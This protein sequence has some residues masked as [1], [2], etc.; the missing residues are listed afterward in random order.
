MAS[1]KFFVKP[2]TKTG[3][4][5]HIRGVTSLSGRQ[6]FRVR[7]NGKTGYVP[8]EKLAVEKRKHGKTCLGTV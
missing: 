1:K 7:Y 5:L 3:K 6:Y 2:E 8:R 4:R